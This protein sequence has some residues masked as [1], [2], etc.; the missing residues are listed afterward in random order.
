MAILALG[1]ATM[2]GLHAME[3][4]SLQQK[5]AEIELFSRRQ[6]ITG[7]LMLE[8]EKYRRLSKGFRRLAPR[9]VEDI[10]EHLT[11]AF[12]K[13]LAELDQLS[14]TPQEKALAV[15]LGEQ[16]NEF[17]LLS[18]KLEPQLYGR[19]VFVK[20]AARDLQEGMISNLSGLQDQAGQRIKRARAE[21]GQQ[22]TQPTRLLVGSAL[23]VL[24]MTGLIL[25]RNYLR[26]S[27]PTAFLKKR[28]E[29]VRDQ[30]EFANVAVQ[31]SLGYAFGEVEKI[32]HDLSK[33]VEALRRERY[34]FVT[35]IARDLRAPLVALQAGAKF[36]LRLP[37][38]T[39]ENDRKAAAEVVGRSVFRLSSTLDDL[40]DI[41]ELE[42]SNSM[43]LDEKLVDVCSLMAATA[44]QL[45]GR[46]SSYPIRVSLPSTPLWVLIDS[47]RVERVI[48]HLISKMMNLMP[49]GGTIDVS[50]NGSLRSGAQGLEIVIQD[51]ERL[52][53]GRGATTGPEQ[54]LLR[55]W[56]SESGLGMALVEKVVK[57]H[58]GTV[59]ASG[60]AGTGV[61]FILRLPQERM[62][63]GSGGIP[64]SL[65]ISLKAPRVPV[66]FKH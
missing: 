50:L 66:I 54:D 20:A 22:I 6:G 47:S 39:S 12:S 61:T 30:K 45:S 15:G 57:A 41:V 21:L 4:R 64:A 28:A 32:I 8:L 38:H 53:H 65:P 14:P 26:F 40:S 1:V 37:E 63:T 49:Q 25:L 24:W 16:I 34:Q 46:G 2:V 52:T 35:A 29:A 58:G 3:I 19:D 42:R 56:V 51:A 43:K 10:K 62:G 27:R 36:L 59:T 17:M 23:I 5:G 7:E 31:K 33:T 60:V 13:G 18:A 11:G 48:V 55:H 44:E 9:E